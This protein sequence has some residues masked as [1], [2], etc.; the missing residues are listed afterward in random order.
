MSKSPMVHAA[1]LRLCRIPPGHWRIVARR[2]GQI[3]RG[4]QADGK[5]THGRQFIFATAV[6]KRIE[7]SVRLQ[8]RTIQDV[9]VRA[10]LG[11][12]YYTEIPYIYDP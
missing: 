9:M 6:V 2:L 11:F 10:R 4:G 1:V 3:V 5:R 8:A 7:I 12:A